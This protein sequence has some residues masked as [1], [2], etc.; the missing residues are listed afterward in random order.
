MY[1]SSARTDPGSS[2]ATQRG[3]RFASRVAAG[4]AAC[5]VV[6]TLAACN[7]NDS[8]T[9]DI[10]PIFPL[11]SDKCATYN[12]TVEGTG[13]LAHCWVGKADCERAAAD[14]ATAM[15]N[16]PDAIKFTC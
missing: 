4:I 1:V 3:G 5:I 11:S 12:G 2:D 8:K 15:K 10:T 13:V 6:V 14:W 7:E 16:V 9:Y